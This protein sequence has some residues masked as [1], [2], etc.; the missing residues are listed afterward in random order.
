VKLAYAHNL[1][2]SK[3]LG[4]FSAKRVKYPGKRRIILWGL[5]ETAEAGTP[6]PLAQAAFTSSRPQEHRAERFACFF[7]DREL[8]IPYYTV[9]VNY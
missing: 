4:C 5:V 2:S 9:V 7:L 8:P 3:K 1:L 6:Q